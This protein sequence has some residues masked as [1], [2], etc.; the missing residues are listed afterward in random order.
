MTKFFVDTGQ[1]SVTSGAVLDDIRKFQEETG[2]FNQAVSLMLQKY[3]P[4]AWI[5]LSGASTANPGMQATKEFAE[6]Q[7]E[8]GHIVDKY[9]L[10]GSY[11]GP[12]TG[13][14][15]PK[16]FSAQR[17]SGFRKP[18]DI[19]ERQDKALTNLAW[20][21]Q[22]TKQQRLI[23]I[24]EKYGYTEKQTRSSPGFKAEMKKTN[25]L[26]KK[27]YPMWSPSASGDQEEIDQLQE[28]ERMVRDK[29]VLATPGGKALKEYW[30]YRNQRVAKII[31]DA[32]SMDNDAWK[33]SPSATRL[34]EKLID[35]GEEII[36]KTPEFT[37]MW[38]NIL[39]REF[40]PP[41]AG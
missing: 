15:D 36:A 37:A 14:Y 12:Q 41:E 38:E 20:N 7:S 16:A 13:E 30:D 19:K 2:D 21:I 34:R 26:L 29:K 31:K 17:A 4:S 28:I 22:R 11:F 18:K 10:T 33:K 23:S 9:P 5:Y 35:K 32:P 24:G 40:E 39:S 27:T 6:W 8:N 1:E 3:G 25:A